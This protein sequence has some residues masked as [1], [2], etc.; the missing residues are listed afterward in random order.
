V[1][2]PFKI[3]VTWIIYGA[4]ALGVGGYIAHCEYTK[5]KWAETKTLADRQA[6]D[7]AKK[8]LRDIRAKERSDE[9]FQ[10]TITRF[11]A[12]VKRLRDRS[13]EYL[14]PASPTTGSPERA[15]FDRAELNTAFRFL[16]DGV[17]RITEE[18]MEAVIKLDE[19]KT[20]A[21]NRE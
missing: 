17:L 8:V 5:T 6:E 21:Q 9:N 2:L 16:R 7:N 14:P 4:I 3:P 15:C 20:W 10:R 1:F 19:A 12:D 13:P 18:G 11:R